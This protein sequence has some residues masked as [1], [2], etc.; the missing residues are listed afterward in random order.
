MDGGS[1]Q[2]SFPIWTGETVDP[3]P[4]QA[5][6]PASYP[7]PEF[8]VIL[9][10]NGERV[11]FRSFTTAFYMNDVPSPEPPFR[12]AQYRFPEF[13]H[14]YGQSEAYGKLEAIGGTLQAV[15]KVVRLQI[16]NTTVETGL[17][18]PFRFDGRV[19]ISDD[20]TGGGG[21]GGGDS[22]GWAY[23]DET[24]FQNGEGSGSWFEALDRYLR[25]GV[26]T[27]GWEVW[28]NGRQVCDGF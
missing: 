15:C 8:T 28:V 10:D 2:G 19:A 16:G 1:V 23:S 6:C 21:G 14:S 7:R 4:E 25:A 17:M 20:T 24:G 26:C 12:A 18:K 22:R 5:D 11:L 13:V 9:V 27:A 3:A